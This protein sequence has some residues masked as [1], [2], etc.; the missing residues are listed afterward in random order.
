MR[1]HRAS[2]IADLD[3]ALRQKF[4]L[5]ELQDFTPEDF[6]KVEKDMTEAK[7]KEILGNPKETLEALGVKRMF[8]NVG[9]KY[10]SISF[11]EGKVQEP[12]GPTSKEEDETMK[13]LMK[14]AKQMEK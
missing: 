6:K 12:L 2:L 10:Y 14:A 3:T 5:P 9:D 8:W 4:F 11:K 7:V 1:R 13:G